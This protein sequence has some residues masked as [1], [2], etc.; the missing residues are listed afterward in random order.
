MTR[1]FCQYYNIRLQPAEAGFPARVGLSAEASF[2]CAPRLTARRCLV[3]R[4]S[5]EDIE[6][7]NFVDMRNLRKP[8]DNVRATGFVAFLRKVGEKLR[9]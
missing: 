9:Q 1:L 8:I 6:Y 4:E 3:G 2:R 7:L 5:A